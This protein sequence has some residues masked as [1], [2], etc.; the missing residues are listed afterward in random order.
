MTV[1]LSPATWPKLAEGQA[2]ADGDVRQGGLRIVHR[3]PPPIPARPPNP[4][5][6]TPA[7]SHAHA[8]P[9]PRRTAGRHAASRQRRQGAATGDP[10]T[11]ALPVGGH[12]GGSLRR[13][14]PFAAM[15]LRK[16]R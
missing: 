14:S 8:E 2:R 11:V 16:R 7:G 1:T 5:S 13:R 9:A 12:A 4:P 6:P 3:A 10:L 15:R